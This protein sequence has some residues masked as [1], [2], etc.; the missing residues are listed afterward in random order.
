MGRPNPERGE[1][2][3]AD[4]VEVRAVVCPQDILDTPIEKGME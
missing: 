2:A 3:M 1:Q 4:L